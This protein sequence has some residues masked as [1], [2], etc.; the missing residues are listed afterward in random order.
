[1]ENILQDLTSSRV[2]LALDAN[3][4]AFGTLLSTLPGAEAHADHGLYWVET[5]VANELFNG[6]LQNSLGR[7]ALPAAIERII[8]H[9]QR[10]RLPFHWHV[11]PSSQ[12][13]SFADL[14]EEQGMKY[15]EDEPGM[16]IDLL[17]LNENLPM[18]T[19]L[20]IHPINSDEQLQQ[21]TRTRGS[22]VTP[23]EVIQ[24]WNR[25]YAGL[26]YGPTKDLRLYLG[27]IDGRPVA[28]VSSSGRRSCRHQSC[29]DHPRYTDGG[30]LAA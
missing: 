2:A 13:T 22:K 14:L 20:A 18:A 21:W 16:A 23:E 6:V 7:E 9:F 19:N 10:R 17:T 1:M 26:P 27:T 5:G 11:G 30:A 29:C 24:H 25:V 3:K 12:H 15:E 8:A 28:T 4:I